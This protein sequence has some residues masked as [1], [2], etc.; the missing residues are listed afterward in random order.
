MNRLSVNLLLKTVIGSLVATV[1]VMLALG[2]WQSWS[3][4]Q[5]VNRITVAAAASSHIFKALHNLRS[6]RTQTGLVLGG[7]APVPT[8]NAAHLKNRATIMDGMKATQELLQ[9]ADIDGAAA[10]VEAL[11]RA[12]EKFTALHAESA[13]AAALPKA[14]RR[15]G[16]AAEYGKESDELLDALAK[17]SSQLTRSVKLAD[18]FVDQMMEVKQLAWTVRDTSG[19]ASALISKGMT[20]LPPDAM[21]QYAVFTGKS[22]TAWAA[23]ED[24][25]AG[26][27]VP[28][29][30][31]QAIAVAKREVFGAEYNT[32]RVNMLKAMVGGQK[33]AMDSAQWVPYTVA[34]LT[35]VIDVAEMAL[36]VAKDYA[37]EQRAI[38]QKQLW[39]QLGLLMLAVIVAAGLIVLVSRRVTGPLRAIQHAMLKLAGG[40]LTADVSFAGRKDE[41]G[42]LAGAMQTFK[43]SMVEADRLRAEQKDGEARAAILRKD[44][45]HKLA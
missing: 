40:D 5:S 7:D 29:V 38:A 22:Q 4:L 20:A 2:A 25:A 1:M 17:L 15:T 13:T 37:A 6:D 18:P 11:R 39:V 9:G 21:L 26:V 30:L 14:A 24:A 12:T 28:A 44:E 41:I 35:T 31:G 27:A 19:D 32:I 45:M 23:L 16:L 3:R 10:A 34:R 8:F 33:P 43:S 36:S 42:G